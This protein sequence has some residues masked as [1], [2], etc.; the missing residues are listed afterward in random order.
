MELNNQQFDL[1]INNKRNEAPEDRMGR[2]TDFHEGSEN[3]K[4]Q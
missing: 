4:S 3:Y 1:R 2:K